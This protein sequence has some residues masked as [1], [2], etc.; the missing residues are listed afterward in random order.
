M[1]KRDDYV[2]GDFLDSLRNAVKGFARESM[3]HQ[4]A[5]ALMAWNDGTKSRRHHHFKDQ[6]S[7]TYQELRAAFG[8]GQFKAINSRVAMFKVTRQ[9][10]SEHRYTK[11]YRLTDGV[12]QCRDD[13]LRIEWKKATTLLYG[14]GATLKTPLAAVASKGMDGITTTAWRR[15]KALNKT[16]VNLDALK[17]LR[18]W[19]VRR[20]DD[21]TTGRISGSLFSDAP[22][23]ESIKYLADMTAQIIRLAK[24][25]VVGHGYV[26]HRYVQARSGRLY[27]KGINLQTA[28]KVI[29]EAALS[30]LW[31]YDFANCHY[32]I[33]SQMAAQFG[34]QCAAIAHYL[35]NK[36]A[37]RRAIADGAGITEDQSKVCLLAI[38][39]GARASEWHDSAIPLA[40]GPDKAKRLYQLDQFAA[41]K[42]DIQGARQAIL[43]HWPRTRNGRLSNAFGKAISSKEP[44]ERRLAHLI[45]GVEAKA[46]KAAIEL[47]PDTIVLMQHDGFAALTRLDICAIEAAVQDATGYRLALE[48]QRIQVDLDAHFLRSQNPKRKAG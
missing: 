20:L 40:I 34:Y 13:Y 27:A 19:L 9:W 44:A 3:P 31:E 33:L 16:R 17:K 26:L 29:K 5:L 7:Y 15:A 30:G 41:I 36:K 48:E 39:Y 35:A 23:A 11:G 6:F 38:M 2:P 4:M 32:A 46:L 24:T 12:Q 28:P 43:K 18:Q 45:Q 14:H 37:T 21:R 10:S 42:A 25:D 8:K 22:N 1:G 47:Y